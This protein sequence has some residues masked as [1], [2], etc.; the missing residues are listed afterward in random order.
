MKSFIIGTVAT[1]IT[2][3][4]VAKLLPQIHVPKEVLSLLILAVIAGLVNG[5]IKPV[6]KILSFPLSMMTFG[7]FG[8]IVNAALLLAIALIAHAISIDF[9]VGGFPPKFTADTALAAVIGSVAMSV[10]GS[11][12]GMAVHD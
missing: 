8:L 10:V 2:F 3:F 4:I 1:A 11:V 12:V 5:L 7:M 9:T 6:A